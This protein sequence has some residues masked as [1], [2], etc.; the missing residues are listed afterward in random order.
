MRKILLAS[1]ALIAMS[2][3]SAMAADISISGST[4][5][6]Y[7]SDDENSGDATG[8]ATAMGTEFDM[9]V[10]FSNTTDSGLSTTMSFG[11]DEDTANLDDAT[12][13]LGGD[14][15]TIRWTTGA[16]DNYVVSMDEA[17][18]TVGEGSGG[19]DNTL[20]GVGGTTIGYQPPS[21]M[22][23][24]TIN[25]EAGDASGADGTASE[26]FG[27]GASMDLGVATVTAAKLSTNVVDQ[28]HVSISGNIAGFGVA[29]EQ[30]SP[31][32]SDN[33]DED[34]STLYGLSYAMDG[35]TVSYE[36]GKTDDDGD[37]TNS[38]SQMQVA[39]TVATGITAILAQSSVDDQTAADADV[40]QTQ[41]QLKVSF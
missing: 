8:D 4:A 22:D 17:F 15:G 9:T 24:L 7:S 20:G 10:S 12:A 28:T 40:E 19:T 36:Q 31:D 1:T 16:D 37:E 41:F 38:Y 21:I 23:G 18:D 13:T 32:S 29:V 14:F 27:Y 39:Y 6:I 33:D 34:T 11:L 5:F 35:V 25:F 26:H 30:I 2:S 3:V